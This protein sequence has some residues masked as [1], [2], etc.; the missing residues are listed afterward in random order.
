LSSVAV[1]DLSLRGNSVLNL[2]EALASLRLRNNR[3]V[4]SFRRTRDTLHRVFD[5]TGA[6]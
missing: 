3:L 4:V 6:G 5:P 1:P 2:R